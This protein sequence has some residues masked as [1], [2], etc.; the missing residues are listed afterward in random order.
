MRLLALAALCGFGA[1]ALGG[2]DSFGRAFFSLGLPRV[3]LIV[4]D[5]PTL[6]G[7]ALMEMGEP[8]AAM[9]VFEAADDPYNQGVAAAFAGDY[10]TALAAWERRLARAPDDHQARA[11]HDL[12]TGLF[13]GTEF[14]TFIEPFRR[15]RDGPTLEAA[16][17]QGNGRAAGEGDGTTNRTTALG[18]PEIS[19]SGL[20]QVPKIFDAHFLAA[21]PQWIET[22]ADEP[23]LYLKARIK[24]ERKARAAKGA[25]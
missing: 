7:A 16:I 14:E 15:E 11:N 6:R 21:S 18:M 20:R 9:K 24:A 2:A 8:A 12:I 1:L 3:T 17:G 13:A 10:A 22:M 25:Q 4:A 5:A 19:A 23:G